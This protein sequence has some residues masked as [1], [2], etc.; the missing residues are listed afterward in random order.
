LLKLKNIAKR[1]DLIYLMS[2]IVNLT[3]DLTKFIMSE[4]GPKPNS[5]A[6]TSPSTTPDGAMSGKFSRRELGRRV[7][8]AAV[9]ALAAK[10]GLACDTATGGD[11]DCPREQEAQ[12]ICPA[13]SGRI[14]VD[15]SEN[16]II[17]CVDAESAA[18]GRAHLCPFRGNQTFYLCHPEQAGER[19]FALIYAAGPSQIQL[20]VDDI[21]DNCELYIQFA[22]DFNFAEETTEDNFPVWEPVPV[23]ENNSSAVSVPGPGTI[24]ILLR[25][26]GEAD[27]DAGGIA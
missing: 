4:T 19:S 25:S 11:D 1:L 22:P 15:S 5:R 16:S 8:A 23:P 13:V 3:I 20:E 27:V 17:Q 21:P 18:Q 26:I 2:I 6:D 14:T 10:F 7:R 12:E 9:L 24:Q